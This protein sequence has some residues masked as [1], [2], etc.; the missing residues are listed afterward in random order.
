MTEQ[1]RVFLLC[2]LCGLV[3]GA[4]YDVLFCAAYPFKKRAVKI[5]ADVLFCV[6]FAGLYLVVSVH[7]RMPPLRLYSFLGCVAGF[8]LYWKSFH[9][10]VAFFAEKVYNSYIK[11]LRKRRDRKLCR[12]GEGTFRREKREGSR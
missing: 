3:G 4:L 6:L 7:F 1:F 9:K 5:G 10:I 2:V 12:K 8:F 11:Q